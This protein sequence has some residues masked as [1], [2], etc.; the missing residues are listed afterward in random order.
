MFNLG[1]GNRNADINKPFSGSGFF[2]TV[3]TILQTILLARDIAYDP[4]LAKKLRGLLIKG[5]AFIMQTT[6][7]ERRNL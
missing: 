6:R 2:Y 1:L 3:R 7:S 4:I 5:S